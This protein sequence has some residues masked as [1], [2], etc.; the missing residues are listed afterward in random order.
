MAIF[1]IAEIGINHN[2]NLDLAKQLIDL[3]SDCGCDAVKF[4]KR[5]IDLVYTKEFLDSRRK[6]PW[7]TTQRAQK[8][9]LEFGQQEFEDIDRYCK[10][11]NIAWF[12]SAWD[13]NSLRFLDQFNCNYAKVAS[14]MLADEIF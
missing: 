12:A 2:G 4:Q 9:G 11:K 7:G 1:I 5:D 3:A 10:E 14:A 6:S 13:L 8:E